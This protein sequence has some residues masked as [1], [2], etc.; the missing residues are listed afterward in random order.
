[1]TLVI[2]TIRSVFFSVI[3]NMTIFLLLIISSFNPAYAKTKIKRI[4]AKIFNPVVIAI[5]AGHGGQDPGATGQHGL[6][7]KQLTLN[8]A[9]HLALLMNKDSM[10]KAILT[11]NGDDFIS[12]MA[13]LDI[14]REHKVNLLISIHA[15]AAPN[16]KVRGASVWLLSYRRAETEMG[17]WLEQHEKQSELLGGAGRVLS[18]KKA[19]PYLST[20][21]LDLQFSHSQRVSYK[22]ALNL[23]K[24]LQKIG[25]IHKSNPENASFGVL[26]SPDI[27]SLLVEMGFISHLSEEKLM[28][29]DRHQKKIAQAL[30][31]GIR[32]YF[33][34]HSLQIT[35]QK[36]SDSLIRH[37]VKRGET[38]FGLSSK[39]KVSISAIKKVNQMKSDVISIGKTLMIP[40]LSKAH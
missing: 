35:H 1:M 25:F 19:N 16:R 20:T 38:L 9:R 36:V 7:E 31:K 4:A 40:V 37:T 12:V 23:L 22:V 30:Y 15:D 6:Q 33:L 5:D 27:P 39:Y 34:T 17:R 3:V 21:V 24:E 28:D 29:T 11:R 10:F 32:H 14:A 13:R 8:V 2:Q 18:N 26:R